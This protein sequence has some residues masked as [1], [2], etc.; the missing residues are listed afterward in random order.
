VTSAQQI[1]VR[2]QRYV[3]KGQKGTVLQREKETLNKRQGKRKKK[4]MDCKE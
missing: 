1:G 2:V 4:R 3:R